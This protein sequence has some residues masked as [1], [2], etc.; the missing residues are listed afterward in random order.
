LVFLGQGKISDED[1]P[2]RTK[3]T[4]MILEEQVKLY[5]EIKADLKRAEG[6]IS[7][8]MDLWTD[9]NQMPYMAVTAHYLVRDSCGALEYRCGLV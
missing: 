3:M 9:P 2:H 5:E 8:T 1:I 6:R 4:A 7:Y